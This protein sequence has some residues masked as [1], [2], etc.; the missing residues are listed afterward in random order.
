M[1]P[2]DKTNDKK[3]SIKR[4][5][6]MDKDLKGPED[7][8]YL[9]HQYKH[10]GFIKN[11]HEKYGEFIVSNL[12]K[13]IQIKEYSKNDTIFRSGDYA[14]YCYLLLSGG[15]DIFVY[16]DKNKETLTATIGGTASPNIRR[17]NIMLSH[18]INIGD[19]F[20]EKD[21]IDKKRRSCT[22]KCSTAS[23]IGELTKND[24]KTIFENHKKL[25]NSEEIRFLN[26]IQIF[27]EFSHSSCEK[28]LE[29]FEKKT[30]RKGELIV[31]QNTPYDRL[32][33]IRKGAFEVVYKNVKSYTSDY[34]INFYMKL[35]ED[36]K[37]RFTGDRLYEIKGEYNAV[38]Y[39]KV[40]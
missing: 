11:V 27:K 2:T 32:I 19:I 33:L 18:N 28:F 26:S 9:Y 14:N 3:L 29:L 1:L 5:M 20:G 13:L 30:Y 22:A 7:I 23:L 37:E 35:N 25:E 36:Y 8:D 21:I 31:K 15:V 17:D 10:L 40:K 38:D 12:L 39:Y 6:T 34:G 16:K 24:Y 4:I